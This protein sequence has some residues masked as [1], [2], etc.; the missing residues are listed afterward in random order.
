[1]VILC[2]KSALLYSY[3]KTGNVHPMILPNPIRMALPT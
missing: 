2:G 1:L 3:I